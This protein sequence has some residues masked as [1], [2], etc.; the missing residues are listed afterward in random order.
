MS[1][2]IILGTLLLTA[3]IFSVVALIIGCISLSLIVGLKNSTHKIQMFDPFTNEVSDIG[4]EAG[5][6]SKKYDNSTKED[7][8]PFVDLDDPNIM[9]TW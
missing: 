2:V 9:S 8:E 1:E 3:L 5:V 4:E 7:E 6:P